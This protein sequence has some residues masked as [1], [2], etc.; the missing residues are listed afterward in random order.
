M[1]VKLTD[2][3]INKTFQ[4]VIPE[5]GKKKIDEELNINWL[6]LTNHFI[7]RFRD[8]L[9]IKE[10]IPFGQWKDIV[11]TILSGKLPGYYKT[12]LKKRNK[13]VFL[14]HSNYNNITLQIPIVFDDVKEVYIATT[15]YVVL[16]ELMIDRYV[17]THEKETNNLQFMKQLHEK[18]YGDLSEKEFFEEFE[19]YNKVTDEKKSFSKSMKEIQKKY[20]SNLDMLKDSIWIPEVENIVIEEFDNGLEMIKPKKEESLDIRNIE[21]ESEELD[22]EIFSNIALDDVPYFEDDFE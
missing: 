10:E 13:D 14:I 15:V 12:S 2:E 5:S 18:V 11:R 22:E 3:I 21:W 6:I 8:R 7:E 17:K 4:E 1:K 9:C 20:V 16:N 19:R